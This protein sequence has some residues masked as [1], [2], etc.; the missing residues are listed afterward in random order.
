MTSLGSGRNSDFGAVSGIT[1]TPVVF[2][3]HPTPSITRNP[4]AAPVLPT[5]PHIIVTGFR[6]DLGRRTS[7]EHALL[8]IF[9][10]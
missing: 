1:I 4:I 6:S 7:S 10:Y 2:A 9:L 3:K 5:T 8:V